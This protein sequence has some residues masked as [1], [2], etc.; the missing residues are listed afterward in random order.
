MKKLLDVVPKFLYVKILITSSIIFFSAVAE[1]LGLGMIMPI[2]SSLLGGSDGG[3]LGSILS[4]IFGESLSLNMILLLMLLMFS[5][6]FIL[7]IAK[8]YMMFGIEW[9]IRGYW[10]SVLY[11]YNTL[12]SFQSFES[13]KGGI[14]TNDIINETLK[15][16]SALRQIL[17][18]LGQSTL[19][20][21]LLTI[22]LISNPYYSS[23]FL[24]V[25]VIFIVIIKLTI[26]NKVGFYGL[27]RQKYEGD[28]YHEVNE[29]I[30][31]MKTIRYLELESFL[32]KRFN[33]RLQKLVR[34]MR[35]NETVRRLPSQIMEI[36][37]I[38]IFVFGLIIANQDPYFNIISLLPF[39]GMLAIVAIKLFTNIGTV[40]SNITAIINLWASV[41]RISDL[42]F[43]SNQKNLVN[44]NNIP[45][46]TH[47]FNDCISFENLDFYYQKEK[48]IIKNLNVEF[49]KGTFNV[50]MGD[51][52]S[53]KSTLGKILIGLYKPING[54]IKIDGIKI[55]SIPHEEIRH[56]I[57][58]VDQ[59][60]FF[61]NGTVI[62]NLQHKLGDID[63]EKINNILALTNAKG[64]VDAL[65]NG[66]NTMIG[67]KGDFLSTGQK[68]RLALARA[69]LMDPSILI[70][71]EITSSLD[72]KSS[73][74]IL[75]TIIKL[76]TSITIIVISHDPLVIDM[77][78]NLFE[79]SDYKITKIR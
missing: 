19:M 62:E 57:G 27:Q 76:K 71:D 7:G 49:K 61:F 32:F 28:V 36:I 16:A 70:L 3:A 54:N 75:E 55:D 74:Y 63:E 66:L 31:G 58:Y 24:I 48:P 2:I 22:L 20:I 38:L 78:E 39:I 64:F 12:K 77:T 29:M 18:F 68:A 67:D 33:I 41:E 34:L 30:N 6:K 17:E 79:L 46:L 47:S 5:I 72:E 50:L 1:T 11:K 4:S 69:L 73:K 8:N 26:M 37:V 51:S 59:E 60:H 25:G 35:K 45:N 9:Q 23:V 56:L 53:G 40:V 65:P 44:Q 42:V 10:M 21:G 52:G 13:Q 15:A 14:I 43:E